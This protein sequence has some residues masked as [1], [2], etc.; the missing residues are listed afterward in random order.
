[1]PHRVLQKTVF[2][3]EILSTM[4]SSGVQADMQ[5][6][7]CIPNKSLKK[8]SISVFSRQSKNQIRISLT[9]HSGVKCF[10][11]HVV[12][13]HRV[14]TSWVLVVSLSREA[15]KIPLLHPYECWE[16]RAQK[17]CF[18]KSTGPR[19]GRLGWLVQ[20]GL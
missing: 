20:E 14:P 2:Q 5:A 7:H 18:E 19:A 3:K 17:D 6:E 11:V 13:A 15:Q 16:C 8:K 10:M 4:P 9:S 1:M 12:V